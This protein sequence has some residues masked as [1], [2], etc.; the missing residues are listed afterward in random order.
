MDTADIGPCRGKAL[1][2]CDQRL[3]CG[4][5]DVRPLGERN[6]MSVLN[7][8]DSVHW[9]ARMHLQLTQGECFT[10]ALGRAAKG[11]V[12]G[13]AVQDTKICQSKL[14]CGRD[15]QKSRSLVLTY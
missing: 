12:E 5:N 10:A 1:E 6:T 8:S 14:L 2:Q 9:Q 4:L 11:K 7:V 13:R 15:S 3:T